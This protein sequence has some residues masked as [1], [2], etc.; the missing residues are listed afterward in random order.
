MFGI[1][2]LAL[3][4]G[5]RVVVV[6]LPHLHTA[7]LVAYVKVGSRFET[8]ADNGLS[9]F[10]EHMLFRGTARHPTSFDLNFAIESL[11]SSLYAETGRDYSMFQIAI[12]ASEVDAGM[13]LF[14]DI[15]GSPR[16]SDIELERALILEEMTEDY[17]SR[18]TE[19]NADDIARGLVFPEHPLGQRIIGPRTNVERFSDE[20]V[21]RHFAS[22]YGA[23][24]T[25]FCVAGPVRAA[26][27]ERAARRHLSTLPEGRAAEAEPAP[28]TQ[29]EP[30]FRYVR[31]R[32][33]QVELSMVFRAVPELDPDYPAS[34]ALLRALD[35]GMATRLHYRLCDQL[36][37]AYSVNAG[38]EP[39]HDVVLLDVVGAAQPGKLAQ[40]I[41]ETLGIFDE[42]RTSCIGEPELAKI[43]RRYRYEIASAVDDA[44]AMASWF[45][46]TSL[47]YAPPTFEERVASME[48]VTAEA[49]RAVA[50]RILRPENLSLAVVGDL[51]R[52]RHTEVKKIVTGWAPA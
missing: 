10:V 45:G 23:R 48:Q 22:F 37:L 31:D 25:L 17:D 26:D 24:N 28:A 52:A 27:V 42:L 9:H 20:D 15:F 8:P 21:A 40:L 18:G 7:T 43:K 34:L 35:D 49:I 51:T 2:R 13:E 36:G 1:T 44:N 11:G 19:I 14:G 5:L 16:F 32:G 29:T 47:Y 30:L 12:E 39:L 33:S 50:R 46:G 41:G 38:I 4:N 6:E 3:E